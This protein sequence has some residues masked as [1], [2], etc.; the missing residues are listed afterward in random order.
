[1]YDYIGN[2]GTEDV[3]RDEHLRQVILDRISCRQRFGVSQAWRVSIHY[4]PVA[5]GEGKM[6]DY[7]GNG[8][9]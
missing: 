7:I 8:G 5:E 6:Y 2:G 4:F 3:R 1:M 9:D